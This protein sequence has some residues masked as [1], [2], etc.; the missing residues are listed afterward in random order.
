[1]LP[2]SSTESPALEFNSA[3]GEMSKKMRIP[4]AK[5]GWIHSIADQKGATFDLIIKDAL[6]RVKFEKKNCHSDN[7]K[8]GELINQPTLLGEELEVM[9]DNLQGAK[10]LKVFL[11]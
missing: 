3:V 11:N 6:G 9:I 5:I 4:T 7:E 2:I 8:F 10:K 1:M